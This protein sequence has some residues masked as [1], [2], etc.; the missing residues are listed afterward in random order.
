MPFLKP[1]SFLF[2]T[3]VLSELIRPQPQPAVLLFTSGLSQIALSV[4]TVEEI[5]YGLAAKPNLRIQAW[6]DTFIRTHCFVL[7]VTEAIAKQAGEM[8][9]KLQLEGKPRTQADMLIAATAKSHQL[10]LVTRNIRDFQGC[11]IPIIDPF[12]L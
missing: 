8:R 7:P 1:M 4:I 2:D 9:G 5:F 12:A 11:D 6:F 10:T 3:N